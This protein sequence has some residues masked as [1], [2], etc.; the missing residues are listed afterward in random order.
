MGKRN[1]K[2]FLILILAVILRLILIN[3]SF[4][5]DEAAQLL[6]SQNS[7]NFLWFGRSADFHPPLFY[8]LT[9][10]W[11]VLG[12]SE[13]VLRLLPLGFGVMSIYFIYIFAK[14]IFNEKTAL[15][16]SLFIAIS[17][18]HIY[19]SQ[20]MRMYSTLGFFGI[21]SMY[22]LW[23]KKWI[24]YLLATIAL[25]YTHYAGLF[26]VA[27]QIIWIILMERQHLKKFILSLAG[28]FIIFL[29]WIPQ[30]LKQLKAGE[31]IL[32]L[33]P[34]WREVANLD[35]FKVIPLTVEKFL[36]GR[37]GYEDKSVYLVL[38][39]FLVSFSGVLFYKTLKNIN[40]Q[41]LF[42][43]NW[44]ITPLVL[45]SL[46]SFFVPMYQPFRLLY[47]IFPFFLLLSLGILSFDGKNKLIIGGLAIA[48]ILTG[49]AQYW[50][51]P[52]LQREDWK[53]AVKYIENNSTDKTLVV[54]E[55]SA[56][57]SPFQ[58]YETKKV[59]NIGAIPGFTKDWT[60]IYSRLDADTKNMSQ[61]YL[62]QYLQ[63]L[64]DPNKNVQKWISD[65]NF[66]LV[67]TQD[68]PGVGFLYNYLK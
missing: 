20:E 34:G 21:L 12:K 1:N 16:T 22:F 29:P 32:I 44:F 50:L 27:T 28:V 42:I 60:I 66:Q 43:L 45:C 58:W 55:F 11:L 47:T 64:S 53:G 18:F 13:F 62:F 33:M 48:I 56:P 38:I 30:L 6:M 52:N 25:I 40:P 5:L 17:Q 39:L 4:W 59:K 67:D 3:Q 68:F 61:I 7:L 54:F 2:I 19:Y 26:L 65:N 37:I 10:Y 8:L 49:L 46:F 63:P 41:K 14:K 15:L 31:N 35:W 57:F 24:W 51:D 23:H 36:Y 9:H